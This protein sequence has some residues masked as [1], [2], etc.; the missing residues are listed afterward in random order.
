MISADFT[1]RAAQLTANSASI[2]ENVIR[3]D[4]PRHCF[5]LLTSTKVIGLEAGA[6]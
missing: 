5:A 1:E 2:L 6:K 3:N 4:A